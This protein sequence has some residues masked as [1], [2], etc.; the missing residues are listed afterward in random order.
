MFL[1]QLP[2]LV[3]VPYTILSSHSEYDVDELLGMVA[4]TGIC[5]DYIPEGQACNLPLGPG[6]EEYKTSKSKPSPE[7]H[8]FEKV[9]MAVENL[10]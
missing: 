4:V 3:Y 8:S 1:C 9:F 10:W 7:K 2:L 6:L 5:E